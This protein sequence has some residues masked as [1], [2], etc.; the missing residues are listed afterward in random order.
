MSPEKQKTNTLSP[1]PEIAPV[2][3]L[4]N[5]SKPQHRKGE[6]QGSLVNSQLT[7]QG[8][9]TLGENS[10]EESSIERKKTLTQ[11]EICK[12]FP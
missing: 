1:E 7:I 8:N 5:V 11:K 3:C 10:R 2:Y 4:E 12:G 9:Q 6:Q